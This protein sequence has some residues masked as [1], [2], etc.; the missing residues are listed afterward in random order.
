MPREIKKENVHFGPSIKLDKSIEKA[1][2]TVSLK[3]Q[4]KVE[5]ISLFRVIHQGN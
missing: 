4:D 5:K 2:E 3:L 1:K